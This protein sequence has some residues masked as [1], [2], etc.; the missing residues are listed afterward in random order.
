MLKYHSLSFW[1]TNHHFRDGFTAADFHKHCDDK[2]PTLT[3]IHS[4]QGFLFGGYSPVP[5]DSTTKGTYKTHPDC[6]I[7]TLTNPHSIPPTKYQLKPGNPHGI[8]C[9]QSYHANFG[10]SAI[11]VTPNSHQNN[12]SCTIFPGSYDDTTGKGTSTF[13]GARN[14]TTNEIEVYSVQ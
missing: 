2:G 12:E 1:L 3:I 9:A 14:F 5:W 11:L 7:F 10:G 4:S 6:F 13:T 8:Y